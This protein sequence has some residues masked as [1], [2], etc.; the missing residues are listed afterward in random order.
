MALPLNYKDKLTSW[1]AG[2]DIPAWTCVV[3]NTDGTVIKGANENDTSFVGVTVCSAASGY[4]AA[5]AGIGAI[6]PVRVGASAIDKGDELIIKDASGRVAEVGT[7]SG[8][9][10]YVVGMAVSD[11]DTVGGLVHMLVNPYVKRAQG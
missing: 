5:V 9:A 4:A 3:C 8:S 6:V 7:T 1:I 2:A 10:Y 11:S